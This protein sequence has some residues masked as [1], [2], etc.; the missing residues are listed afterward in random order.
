MYAQAQRVCRVPKSAWFYEMRGGE[1]L[2]CQDENESNPLYM[3]NQNL[4]LGGTGILT[5]VH[6][7]MHAILE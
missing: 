2:C 6:I 3:R 5:D 4:S 7:R 1:K